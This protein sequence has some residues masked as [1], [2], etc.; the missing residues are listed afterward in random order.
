[1]PEER[2]AAAADIRQFAADDQAGRKV[3]AAPGR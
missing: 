2:T 3:K 1:L